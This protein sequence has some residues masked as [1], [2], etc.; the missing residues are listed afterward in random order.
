[1]KK[2]WTSYNIEYEATGNFA[3]EMGLPPIFHPLLLNRGIRSA[4]EAEKYLY[5]DWNDVRSPLMLKDMK[6]A[7]E[8]LSRSI[9]EG[10]EICIYGDYDADGT[11]ATSILYRGLKKLGA[12]LSYYIPNRFEEG[13]GLNKEAL[14]Q[15]S[16]KGV[17]LVITVDCG[18]NSVEVVEYGMKLGLEIIITDHHQC[19]EALPDCIAVIN[20]HQPGCESVFK[21]LCGSGVALKLLMALSEE[22]NCPIPLEDSIVLCAIATVA[23]LVPLTGENRIIVREGLKFISKS[24]LLGVRAML[25]VCDLVNKP[26]T[27]YTFGFQIGPRINAA[28]RLDSALAVVEL[29]TTEDEIRA[30]EIAENLNTENRERQR[31]EK[32]ITELAMAKIEES[33]IRDTEKSIVVADENWH[34]GVVG[35]VAS[36][37][38][39]KYYL[40]TFVISTDGSH[41]KGSA[42]SVPGFHLFQNMQLVAECFEK[43]GGH[44]MAAGFSLQSEKIGELREKIKE[45]ALEADKKS[46]FIP[47]IKVDYR[48][49]GNEISREVYDEIRLL[50]PFGMGNPSPIFVCRKMKVLSFRKIGE[51]GK[52]L[53]LS[54]FDGEKQ[55]SAVAFQKGELYETLQI[56]GVIDFVC[57]LDLNVWNGFEKIQ[58]NIRDIRC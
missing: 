22:R 2:K 32:E 3:R 30:R 48:L 20:P 34:T 13:Y 8:H 37:L 4:E 26:I 14:K 25:Q 56:N 24:S 45:L 1:M 21:D 54:L 40:P 16:E 35:I 52:H 5:G 12:K 51:D 46:P 10:K 11:L 47:Q 57:S 58:L 28:G 41:A 44:E 33:G 23:D 55:L 50:E 31:I 17:D 29:F 6:K 49:E 15:L 7:V 53:S 42:R 9:S 19:G 43:F 39:E 38:V 36:R 27:A 18:I